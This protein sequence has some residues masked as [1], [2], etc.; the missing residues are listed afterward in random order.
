MLKQQLSRSILFIS[1][2]FH[3]D[4][5]ISDKMY[6]Q[7]LYRRV[8]DRKLNLDK[9]ETYSEKLQWL[10]LYNRQ[11][12]FTTMVDKYAVKKYVA[13]LI[14]EEYII[15]TIG[16]WDKP[17]NIDWDSLPNQ[18]VLKCSHD[19][20]GLVIC[21]DKSLINRKKA[22]RKLKKSLK[23]DYYKVGREWPYKNVHPRILAEQFM[24]DDS[25]FNK[26][27]LTDYKFTCFNG[28]ADNVMVCIGRASGNTKFYFFDR[29]WNL[30]PLNVRGK[31][32][33]P[34]FKLP[35]PECMDKMFELAGKLSEG[36][37]YLRVDLYCINGRPY[38]GETTF[39]P[40]S[41]FD[42]NILP[43]TEKYFGDKIVLPHT[44]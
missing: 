1:R 23:R 16:V 41:G 28:T 24:S 42:P 37:P 5:L 7:L 11:P 36:I 20:G 22:I 25:E 6:I 21:R 13:D 15:P 29:E 31:N 38:F 30:L 2:F 40:S 10:K 8:F 43:E 3:V 14:G 27:G 19:C 18:F 33:D 12:K 26:D 44:K 17:E 34:S 9:P 4:G 39:F 35:K 32:T